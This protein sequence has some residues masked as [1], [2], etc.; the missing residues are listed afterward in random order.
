[1]TES[2]NDDIFSHVEEFVRISEEM[3]DPRID[4]LLSKIVKMLQKPDA[5]SPGNVAINII[6]LEALAAHFA[7]MATYYKTLGKG[8]VPE[9]YRKDMYY[10]AKESTQRLVDALKYVVR[11]HEIR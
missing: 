7:K 4:E 6:R 2:I 1:M 5:T 8:G 10:T 11:V 3:N 9:R